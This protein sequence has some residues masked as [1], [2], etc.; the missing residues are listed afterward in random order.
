M[1]EAKKTEVLQGEVVIDGP[2]L[3]TLSKEYE[4]EG[5]KIREIDLSGLEDVT[6]KDM[7]R[8]NRTLVKT[9]GGTGDLVPEITLPYALVIAE[10]CTKYPIEFYERLNPRD[11]MK[12][13]TTVVSFMFGEE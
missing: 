8:A 2:L 9:G 4:F 3:I 7:M 12:V 6:A 13:R 1:A 10:Q 11:A 5:E